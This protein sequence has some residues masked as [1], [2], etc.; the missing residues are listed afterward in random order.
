MMNRLSA[1]CVFLILGAALLLGTSYA[2]DKDAKSTERGSAASGND[3]EPTAQSRTAVREFLMGADANN[4]GIRDDLAELLSMEDI[5]TMSAKPASTVERELAAALANSGAARPAAA[6]PS[7]LDYLL[8]DPKDQAAANRYI[9]ARTNGVFGAH[10]C[11]PVV[12]PLIE[13]PFE[14]DFARLYLGPV[15][16]NYAQY[17]K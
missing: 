15:Q 10:P 5:T 6:Q 2:Q 13:R 9:Q 11:D 14:R 1:K 12:S 7:C 3:A 16:L 4:D 17:E 8:M